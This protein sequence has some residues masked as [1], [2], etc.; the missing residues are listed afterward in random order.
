MGGVAIDMGLR[1]AHTRRPSRVFAAWVSSCALIAASGCG[2]SGSSPSQPADLPASQ[3]DAARFLMQATFGPRQEDIEHLSHTGYTPWLYEQRDA[4]ISLQRPALEDELHAGENVYQNQR[5]ELWWKYAVQGQD[6]LRQRVAWALSQIFVISDVSG[7]ISNDPIGMAEYYDILARDA[8]GNYR[9]LLEDVTLSPQMGRYLNVLKNRKADPAHNI[10]PDE[11]YA[12]E[13]MQLF[14]IGLYKLAPDGTRMLDSNGN[15]IPTY[16]QGVVEA[17]AADYTG[18]NY[19]GATS[20]Q[21]PSAN[22]RTGSCTTTKPSRRSSTDRCSPPDRRASTTWRTRSTACSII[23]TWGRSS[24]GSSS[25]VW[26]RA[27]RARATCSA[28]PR[29]S[30]TMASASAAISSRS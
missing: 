6:Q 13:V 21:W 3:Q 9:A 25:S 5:V 27:T 19:A 28:S 22:Y 10:H 4:P 2:G 12:R 11:N 24:A 8:F 29:R 1:R 7:S 26:S 16:D 30:R 18:W 17:Y 23:R 14:T 20:W 15:L